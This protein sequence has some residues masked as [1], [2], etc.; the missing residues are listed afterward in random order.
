MLEGGDRVV[1]DTGYVHAVGAQMK[2]DAQAFI[3]SAPESVHDFQNTLTNL[4]DANFPIQLYS[5]FYQFINIHTTAFTQIFQDRQAIGDTLQDSASK[6]E[7]TEVKTVASF[8]PDPISGID[9]P[10]QFQF[11]G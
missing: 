7:L 5:T 4:N 11:P 10:A 6:A 2:Q 1:I 9:G 3:D 8:T